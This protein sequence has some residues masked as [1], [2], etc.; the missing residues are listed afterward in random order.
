[1]KWD[2]LSQGKN[3]GGL[4]LRDFK[5]FNVAMLAKQGWRIL[6]S[7]H[8]LP[9]QILKQKYFP[10]GEFLEAKLGYRPSYVWRSIMSGIEVL[11]EGLVWRIGND[12]QVRIW[13]DKLIP[14]AHTFRI[15]ST[16]GEHATQMM[17][18]ELIDEDL[19]SWN[20]PLLA[21]LFSAQE[22]DIIK[23]IPLSMGGREDQLV[24]HYTKN[25][26]FSVRIRSFMWRACNEALPTMV[27]LMKRKIVENSS[28]RAAKDIW[29]QGSRQIQKMSTLCSSF[30]EV[31]EHL[32][33]NLQESSLKEVAVIARLIWARRND[34][35]FGKGF[36]DP[37][38]IVNKARRELELFQHVQRQHEGGLQRTKDQITAKWHRPPIGW[39]KMNWDAAISEAKGQVGIGGIIRNSDGQVM[40][41]IQAQR[42][43]KL[44]AFSG[45]AYAMIMCVSFCRE[46][47]LLNEP[48]KD[49]SCG[50]LIIEEAKVLLFNFA[51]WQAVH[52]KRGGNKAAHGLAQEALSLKFCLAT[53]NSQMRILSFKI[54][55]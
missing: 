10:N 4:D 1:M 38:Q 14:K 50:G 13:E 46:V 36:M 24:W 21:R 28:C 30:K 48:Q 3:K 45:E 32:S 37:N 19:R 40:A 5:S 39:Y 47:G 26:L 35:I 31:W 25:S 16:R 33:K 11:K 53:E 41:T 12:R 15:Q 9:T 29:S 20:E 49:W 27:N 52:T 34:F 22:V 54:K 55:Y 2:K 23:S 6:Q 8:S 7:P 18:S 51:E 17:V 44:E 43:L 42:Q